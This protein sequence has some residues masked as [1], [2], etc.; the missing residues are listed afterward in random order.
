MTEKEHCK[1]IYKNRY[2]AQEVCN[3]LLTKS[4]CPRSTIHLTKYVSGFCGIK[5]CEGTIPLNVNGNALPTCKMWQ[6]CACDCHLEYDKMFS[7]TNTERI[8]V[9]NSKYEPASHAWI[10]PDWDELALARLSSNPV[11]ATAPGVIKSELP[12]EIPATVSREWTP[13]PTG[14]AAR[15]ELESQI[16]WA[17]DVWM[18]D[19]DPEFCTLSHVSEEIGKHYGI[20]PP[21]LGA[22]DAAWKRWV[23]IGFANIATKPIRFES[24]TEEGIKLTLEGCK[25][26]ARRKANA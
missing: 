8:A 22:I 7:M 25:E 24:Y 4:G 12:D 10:M 6:T 5:A 15:G 13:T 26:R 14:R 3:R 21:S 16:K 11:A 1:A 2:G 18:V 17:C 23:L 20:R 19:K 9:N